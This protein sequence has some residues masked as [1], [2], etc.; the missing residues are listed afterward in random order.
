MHFPTFRTDSATEIRVHLAPHT[1][2]ACELQRRWRKPAV[3]RKAS[4]EFI[5]GERAG[6]MDRLQDWIA[7]VPAK[8]SINWVVGPTE[9]LYFTLPWSPAWVDRS[10][11]DTFA[12]ERFEQLFERDARTAAF[13]FADASPEGGQLVSCISIE[14]H[15]ELVAHAKRSG[16]ALGG[17]KPSIAAVWNRFR[18]VLETEQGT[19]CVVDGDQQ[20]IVRHNKSRIEDIFV[21]PCSPVAKVMASRGGVFRRFTNDPAHTPMGRSGDLQLPI[22]RGFVAA[23]DATYA[24]ALCGA[25]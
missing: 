17:I 1:L 19:L 3:T 15:A 10:L 20:T 22:R 23:Q 5:A 4:F 24:F 12:R 11:R 2:I 25:L 7:E 16:C 9:A 14:L 6:A 21:R 13:C 8:R 18:G